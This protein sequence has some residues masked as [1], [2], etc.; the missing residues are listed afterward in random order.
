MS[1]FKSLVTGAKSFGEVARDILSSIADKVIDILMTPIF[2]N[3]AGS[4]AGGI[5]KGLGGMGASF[6]GGG[7]TGTG[8]RSGGLDG[9]GGFMAMVH[10][11]E[12]VLDHTKGQG[13]GGN[14]VTVNMTVNTPDAGSFRKS[15]AQIEADLAR[16]ARAGMRGN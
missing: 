10:P 5:M 9:R 2:N 8:S 11:N 16:I 1:G 3:I 12:T 14:H 7:F 6:E 13:V 4:L 15:R